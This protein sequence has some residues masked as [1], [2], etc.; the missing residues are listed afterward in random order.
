MTAKN[1]TKI[2]KGKRP[3]SGL[4]VLVGRARHQASALSTDLRDRGA[5]VIE[6]P[7][8]DIRKPRS[9]RLLDTALKN[10]SSYD[11]LILT[12]VNG[13]DALWK[14]L[15]KLHLTKLYLNHLEV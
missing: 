7:F 13:V 5:E 4:R 12:S 8:I 1:S 2:E 3:L 15:R 10:I 11:L 6:I 14:R 9:Y